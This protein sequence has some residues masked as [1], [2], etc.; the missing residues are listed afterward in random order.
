MKPEELRI[1]NL[2]SDGTFVNKIS[3]ADFY[4][5][6]L[7]DNC[8]FTAIPITKEWLLKFGFNENY[9]EYDKEG[10]NLDCEY[11]DKGEW[12]TFLQAGNIKPIESNN[13]YTCRYYPKSDI[14]YVHE[15][16]NLYF[17]LTKEE[18]ELK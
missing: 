8:P 16:Q 14:K 10:I 11:T 5:M 13:E 15:L 18:L 3:L 4:N 6:H 9:G 12:I 1:G 17:A 2:V 7:D